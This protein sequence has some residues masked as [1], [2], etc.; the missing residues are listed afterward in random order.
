MVNNMQPGVEVI[1]SGN[2][3]AG[4]PPSPRAAP[5]RA[6]NLRNCSIRNSNSQLG[7]V[8]NRCD[9]GALMKLAIPRYR[10]A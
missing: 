6:G 1:K 3:T 5:H 7:D 4:G 10:N 9:S 2:L 8:E